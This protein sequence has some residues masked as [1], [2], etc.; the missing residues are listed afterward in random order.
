M[1][2]D[3]QRLARPASGWLSA[4]SLPIKRVEVRFG[5]LLAELVALQPAAR[6]RRGMIVL[7]GRGVA[8]AQDVHLP[9][10][11]V[12]RQAARRCPCVAVRSTMR[13]RGTTASG[14]QRR[15]LCRLRRKC[16][17]RANRRLAADARDAV[18]WPAARDGQHGD[19]AVEVLHRL[20]LRQ[21]GRRTAAARRRSSRSR[22]R[23]AWTAPA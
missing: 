6:F 20:R 16:C 8:E 10:R 17:A 18:C 2:V 12:P 3:D 22:R 21:H 4:M 13:S 14:R 5:R 1:C 11:H 15:E 19:V 7:A 23:A 9:G